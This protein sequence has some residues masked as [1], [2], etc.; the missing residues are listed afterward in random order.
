MNLKLRPPEP[1]VLLSTYLDTHYTERFT[2]TDSLISF[3]C[4]LPLGISVPFLRGHYKISHSQMYIFVSVNK[5]FRSYDA[6]S[7]LLKRIWNPGHLPQLQQVSELLS[8]A[9]CQN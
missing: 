2:I 1:C 6:K 8:L 7:H 3:H 5:R 4:L 9:S